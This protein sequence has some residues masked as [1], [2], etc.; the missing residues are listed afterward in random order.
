MLINKSSEFST[1]SK[2]SETNSPT[3]EAQ[4]AV[5]QLLGLPGSSIESH[6]KAANFL[7]LDTFWSQTVPLDLSIPI[8]REM[9]L[10]FDFD[11]NQ[12]KIVLTETT[13]GQAS[14]VDAQSAHLVML[15]TEPA[16]S[17]EDIA[18]AFDPNLTWWPTQAVIFSDNLP[19][20]HTGESMFSD[21]S[22]YA[23]III[24]L[25]LQNN[26]AAVLVILRTK[27]FKNIYRQMKSH[28]L[29]EFNLNEKHPLSQKLSIDK[30]ITQEGGIALYRGFL[31]FPPKH[32][33][34]LRLRK[35]RA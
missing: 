25:G 15:H 8:D 29:K 21:P 22:I 18:L 19:S 32:D 30:L 1:S 26:P 34:I 16:N 11:K 9:I 2:L 20:P 23:E 24:R 10:G 27:G 4:E 5:H 13:L 35:F 14:F 6:D 7:R 33:D 17:A 31:S 3:I 12:R 28:E